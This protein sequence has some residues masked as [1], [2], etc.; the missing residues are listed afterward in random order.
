MVTIATS[1]AETSSSRITTALVA[2]LAAFSRLGCSIL[3]SSS[4]MPRGPYNR[5]PT[6]CDDCH[7]VAHAGVVKLVDTPALG[8]G[9]ASL[10]GSSPS[11]RTRSPSLKDLRR[12]CE[13]E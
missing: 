13:W 12:S 8:A 10:G 11:A 2:L 9:G 6:A 7:E 3:T 5:R 1:A 4:A